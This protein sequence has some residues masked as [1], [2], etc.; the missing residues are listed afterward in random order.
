MLQNSENSSHISPYD[1]IGVI[2]RKENPGWVRG[3]S[4]GA[5]PTLAFEQLTSRLSV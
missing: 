5:Y 2:F 4:H 1:L 3:L